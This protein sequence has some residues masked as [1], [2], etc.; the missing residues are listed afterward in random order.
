M[1]LTLDQ[2]KAM[3]ES[4]HQSGIDKYDIA[5]AMK[6]INAIEAAAGKIASSRVE[7][8]QDRYFDADQDSNGG[9][10]EPG[11][12]ASR[13]VLTE[14]GNNAAK[15]ITRI[16]CDQAEPA[17]PAKP[18]AKPIKPTVLTDSGVV[19]RPGTTANHTTTSR[20]HVEW[21]EGV[22]RDKNIIQA[23]LTACE[24]VGDTVSLAELFTPLE[25]RNRAREIAAM[26]RR[27]V[28]DVNVI[29]RVKI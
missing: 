1:T 22:E 26:D 20:P 4:L 14:V 19:A 23:M 3:M 2:A 21:G 18:T 24:Q 25:V 6:V 12:A 28:R 27:F 11:R 7:P 5:T 8:L 29:E 15:V 9:L 16:S 17:A 10:S 13:I